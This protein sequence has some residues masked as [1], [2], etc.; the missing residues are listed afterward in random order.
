MY[1][2]M[3]PTFTPRRRYR[4]FRTLGSSILI[5]TQLEPRRRV[6]MKT[7]D[8]VANELAILRMLRG[9]AHIV[10][11]IDV[12]DDGLT[13]VI[14]YASGGDLYQMLYGTGRRRPVEAS[15]AQVWTAQLTSALIA[16]H[17]RGVIHGDIKPENILFD[18][19]SRVKLADFDRS[20]LRGNGVRLTSIADLGTVEFTSPE[21]MFD[22][23]VYESTDVWCLGLVVFEMLTAKC[24]LEAARDPCELCSRAP[25]R[26]RYKRSL[27]CTRCLSRTLKRSD[28]LIDKAVSDA[29]L[30]GDVADFIRKACANEH[31]RRPSAQELLNLPWLLPFLMPTPLLR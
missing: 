23:C 1:I 7:G 24:A 14:P 13:I 17:L 8:H 29:K 2:L 18:S 30:Q 16:C 10:Q 9:C 15:S 4:S 25:E 26:K 20:I 5:A 28:E 27:R 31:R 11:L 3:S 12:S 21:M 6:V 19:Q 22:R